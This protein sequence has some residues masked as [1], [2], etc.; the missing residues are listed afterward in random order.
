MEQRQERSIIAPGM[1]LRAEASTGRVRAEARNAGALRCLAAI[2]LAFFVPAASAD[3]ELLLKRIPLAVDKPTAIE[4]VRQVF[5]ERGWQVTAKDAGSVSATY[6]SQA[7]EAKVRIFLA[8][9]SL[10]YEET[11]LDRD[12][13]RRGS[14]SPTI[15]TPARW[16]NGLI[17]DVGQS[18][19]SQ[20]L[21]LA[22]SSQ[23]RTPYDRMAE[24]KKMFDAGLISS[25]EYEQ[26]R[27]DIL[28]NL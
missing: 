4:I 6:V 10:R 16:I 19:Q 21:D 25:A 14:A 12:A 23:Q 3:E 27:A 1:L 22:W 2:T 26:K 17:E 7:I 15:R 5:V 9:R 11:A 8:D 18:L 24:L 28:K 20:A 13:A